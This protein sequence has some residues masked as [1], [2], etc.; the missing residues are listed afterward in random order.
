MLR[1]LLKS[2]IENYSLSL[3][4]WLTLPSMEIIDFSLPTSYAVVNGYRAER[5]GVI[6]NHAD[7][8]S[9]GMQYHPMLIGEEFLIKIGAMVE[10]PIWR[11]NLM[12]DHDNNNHL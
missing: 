10:T 8:L 6:A 3:H 7:K 11:T 9:G 12:S 2:G 5:G 1:N 4:A